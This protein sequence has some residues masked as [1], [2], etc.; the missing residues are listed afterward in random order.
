MQLALDLIY[1]TNAATPHE[2]THAHTHTRARVRMRSQDPDIS[3]RQRA[4]DLIYQLVTSKNVAGNCGWVGACVG[5]SGCKRMCAR[6][7]ARVCVF[8]EAWELI[9]TRARVHSNTHAHTHACAHLI[10]LMRE[11]LNYLVVASSDQKYVCARA[12]AC[13]HL[14]ACVRAC[15]RTRA[16][17]CACVCVCGVCSTIW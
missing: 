5:V 10:D 6:A 8:Q 12:C 3:I 11:M 4:L 14:C 16:C 1:H 9:K 7:R 13:E 15:M 2:H 17:A